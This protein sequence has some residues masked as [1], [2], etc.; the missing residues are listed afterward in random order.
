MNEAREQIARAVAKAIAYKQSGNDE[1]AA[2]W[3]RQVVLLMELHQLIP[4][5]PN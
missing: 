4:T 2:F 5:A 1:K 3:G